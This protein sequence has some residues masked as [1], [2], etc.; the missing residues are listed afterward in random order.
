MDRMFQ[1][2]NK[3]SI[4]GELLTEMIEKNVHKY[5]GAEDKNDNDEIFDGNRI[6]YYKYE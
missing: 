1:E 4:D 5:E 2:H 3:Y 6:N